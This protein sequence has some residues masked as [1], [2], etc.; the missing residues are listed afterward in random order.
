MLMVSAAPAR[1]PGGHAAP[2]VYLCPGCLR[3][4]AWVSA[5]YRQIADEGSCWTDLRPEDRF[6]VILFAGA[7]RLLAPR[8]VA[9]DPAQLQYADQIHRRPGRA[10]G[11]PNWPGP[12]KPAWAC[13]TMRAA[14]APWSWSR[15]DTSPRKKR[16][17][18]GFADQVGQCN[19]FAFGI[20]SSVN[21]YSDRRVGQSRP[22][23]ALRGHRT[24][25]GRG[26]RRP[27]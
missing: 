16:S 18:S 9:A 25:G 12:L 13:P 20:G 26:G 22:G 10:A 24:P 6:N 7:A 4:H 19:V 3:F 1:G 8:S 2:G 17:S 27:L 23:R 11:A 21:R 14:P 5:G 15:M